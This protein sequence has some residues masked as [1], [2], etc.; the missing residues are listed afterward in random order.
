MKKILLLLMLIFPVQSYG[1]PQVWNWN[2]DGVKNQFIQSDG[3][4]REDPIFDQLQKSPSKRVNDIT[5]VSRPVKNYVVYDRNPIVHL[6]GSFNSPRFLDLN[7]KAGELYQVSGAAINAHSYQ[8]F[9]ERQNLEYK[10]DSQRAAWQ[11][12][13]AYYLNNTTPW[14]PSRVK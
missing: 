4:H 7:K 6:D 2:G 14:L 3:K 12:R 10:L 5:F 13:R 8:S 1:Q 9:R 11:S